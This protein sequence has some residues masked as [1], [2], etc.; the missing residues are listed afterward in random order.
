MTKTRC[1]REVK[2]KNFYEHNTTKIVQ[3]KAVNS[4]NKSSPINLVRRNLQELDYSSSPIESKNNKKKIVRK[5]KEKFKNKNLPIPS[6]V[7]PLDLNLKEEN[8]NIH[9]IPQNEYEE[10]IDSIT[11]IFHSNKIIT[12]EIDGLSINFIYEEINSKTYIYLSHF[13]KMLECYFKMSI[14]TQFDLL[15]IQSPNKICFIIKPQN[16]FGINVLKKNKNTNLQ[17]S[18]FK[19]MVQIQFFRTTN[20]KFE[21]LLLLEFKAEKKNLFIVK[22]EDNNNQVQQILFKRWFAYFKS[23]V[24]SPE[25]KQNT[26]ETP[27]KRIPNVS[28]TL[29]D[30]FKSDTVK[31]LTDYYN[32]SESEFESRRQFFTDV[33]NDIMESINNNKINLDIDHTKNGKKLV[34]QTLIYK[35]FLSFRNEHLETTNKIQSRTF[36]NQNEQILNIHNKILNNSNQRQSST[37]GKSLSSFFQ[38]AKFCINL[39]I[40]VRNVHLEKIYNPDILCMFILPENVKKIIVLYVSRLLSIGRTEKSVKTFLNNIKYTLQNYYCYCKTLFVF[41]DIQIKN[42]INLLVQEIEEYKKNDFIKM[43]K[44]IS[45]PLIDPI[46]AHTSPSFDVLK[47]VT[48]SL[49]EKIVESYQQENHVDF[50]KISVYTCLILS[51]KMGMRVDMSKNIIF[52]KNLYTFQELESLLSDTRLKK[53]KIYIESLSSIL[54]NMKY[55]RNSLILFTPFIE[56]SRVSK[57]LEQ[58]LPL[59][60]KLSSRLIDMIILSNMNNNNK[61]NEKYKEI[62]FKEKLDLGEFLDEIPEIKLVNSSKNLLNNTRKIFQEFYDSNENYANHNSKKYDYKGIRK[63]IV[64]YFD[65]NKNNTSSDILNTFILLHKE[66]TKKEYYIHHKV[67]SD[68]IKEAINYLNSM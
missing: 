67:S 14:N 29:H 25:K 9:P 38:F 49:Y 65:Q 21:T 15:K 3:K 43:N 54:K 26:T 47:E 61:N 53:I 63:M 1:G 36:H 7:F 35:Q 46:V 8:T 60:D 58:L 13:I 44:T 57:H 59:G 24:S 31:S 56:N 48:E 33:I 19:Q 50:E 12:I 39:Y 28:N 62:L 45:P 68:T 18:S 27:K 37:V 64:N 51:L 52:R 66:E 32:M 4:K 41:Y 17:E 6:D 10:Q 22:N 16:Y 40:A 2:Q 55:D 11:S 23:I 42:R 20:V 34:E 5:K 30:I